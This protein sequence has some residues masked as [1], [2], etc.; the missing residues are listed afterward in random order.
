M[1][2]FFFVQAKADPNK[3]NVRRST[4]LH[5]AFKEAHGGAVRCLL[6]HGASWSLTRRNNLHRRPRDYMPVREARDEELVHGG[7]YVTEIRSRHGDSPWEEEERRDARA[8]EA[9][10]AVA[11]GGAGSSGEGG[12]V[13]SPS[14]GERKKAKLLTPRELTSAS[15]PGRAPPFRGGGKPGEVSGAAESIYKTSKGRYC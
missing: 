5:R 9:A 7:M 3:R 2:G 14:G 15:L 6:R 1:G 11:D 10:A 4:A 12:A 13:G 8:R